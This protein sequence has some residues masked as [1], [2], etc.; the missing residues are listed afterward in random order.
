[1]IRTS[2]VVLASTGLAAAPA[3]AETALADA[4]DA[5]EIVVK[6]EAID[7]ADIAY[8]ATVLT[9]EEIRTQAFGDFDDIFRFVPGMAVRD[10]GLGGVANGIVIRGFGNGGH[11]GDLGAVVDGIPLNEAMS[12]ADGYVD[13]NLIVPIEVETM[14]VYRGPVSAL[15]GNYNRG[16]LVNIVTRK[17]GDYLNVD[18]N[19]G[20]FAT[21]DLQFALGKPIGDNQQ[22][23]IAG[24]YYLTDGYRPNSDAERQTL[25][26]R[27]AIDAAPGFQVALSTRLHHAD[28]NSESYLT[29][30]QFE[31]D[32]YGIDLRA[33]NDGA[34]KNFASFRADVNVD[35][36]DHARL[37]TFAYATRQDFTRWFSRPVGG[38]LW[39]QR[40]ESYDRDIFGAGTSLN[41]EI[42]LGADAKPLTYAAG[43]ETF[44]ER[45]DF[46]FYDGL[47]R[48]TRQGPAA[49]DRRT[50]L[51]SVSAFAEVNA[52][53]HRLLDVSLGLRGDRFT[54][55]CELRG[56][57][58]GSDP[59]G[60]LETV[61]R[62][63][64][65]L[66]ARSQV[67]PWLQL[68]G[69][70][71]EGFALPNNFV[72]YAIGGQTLDPNVFRQTEVG[73]K[74]TPGAGVTLDVAAYRLTSTD[75]VRTLA[76]GIYENFGA[77]RRRG[78]E[79]SAEWKPDESFWLRGVYGYTD[80]EVRENGDA[81][82]IGLDVA[83]VPR[84]TANIDARWRP[85]EAI[86]LEANWRLVGSYAV[87]ALNTLR[88][89]SYDT[90]D[91]MAAYTATAPFGYRAYV[92][93]DNVTDREYATSVSQIGGGTVVAPG[94]P[95]AVRV[96]I[97]ITL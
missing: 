32:P 26:A 20:S 72:K 3:L 76:P 40:E 93:V 2:L 18:A 22:I 41:G 9:P 4:V 27:W 38:G 43:V 49:N 60:D 61:E 64:P 80:T 42:A 1:M 8:S 45:T 97:Q 21:G 50:K 54:G 57:E 95:R 23:N 68:R 19:M 70:W 51:N 96:G 81:R 79:A 7:A 87:D 13:F 29:Q 30:E 75:E 44:R 46:E 14:T 73:V 47:S 82:L 89:E 59:C 35:V 10:F 92:R 31:T 74:L 78:I 55:G 84:H 94:A 25:V 5:A 11:G 53:L 37:L 88:A 63:S 33:Q 91:L 48:R 36:A 39:R 58:T 83:G 62:L 6:G 90:V 56:P 69:S 17:G 15:Y 52:P 71:A 66:G 86:E 16:G 24:Q 34:T 77:T 28:A 12:H 65:K 85:V 67:A